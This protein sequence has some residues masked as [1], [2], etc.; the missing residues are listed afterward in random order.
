M[1]ILEMIIAPALV[2]GLSA[3]AEKTAISIGIKFG[4]GMVGTVGSFAAAEGIQKNADKKFRKKAADACSNGKIKNKK[5][6]DKFCKNYERKTALKKAL[7][8]GAIGGAS[9]VAG[10][11]ANIAAMNKLENGT[12]SLHSV[13]PA[14]CR[15][16]ISSADI[17]RWR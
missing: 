12:F 8:G 5:D 14:A 2:S 15:Y 7:V 11:A 10:E 4:A 1:A 3:A 6:A 16:S 9:A 13:Q 17:K